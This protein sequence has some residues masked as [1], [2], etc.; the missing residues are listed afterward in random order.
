[1]YGPA[2]YKDAGNAKEMFRRLLIK[3]KAGGKAPPA[4][5]KPKG[6]TKP[7]ADGPKRGGRGGAR[8]GRAGGRGRQKK[9]NKEEGG[10]DDAGAEKSQSDA[11]EG[12]KN[13]SRAPCV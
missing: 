12:I 1:M 2:G 8:G 4:A 6:V 9:A 10:A 5:A 7:K 13:S 3:L 11:D